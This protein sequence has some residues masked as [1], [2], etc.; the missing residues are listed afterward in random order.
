MTHHDLSLP[1]RT[2]DIAE[3]TAGLAPTTSV[4]L[5]TPSDAS[6]AA[7]RMDI[8]WSNMRREAKAAGSPQADLDAITTLIGETDIAGPT[9]VAH[10][11]GETLIAVVSGGSVRGAGFSQRPITDGVVEVSPVPALLPLL[12]GQSDV[13][14]HLVVTIDRTGADVTLITPT[15]TLETTVEGDDEHIHRGHPGGWSQRRFQQRAENTWE[16]NSK[17]VAEHV[18]DLTRR[19]GPA[20]IIVAGDERAIGFFRQHLPPVVDGIVTEIRGARVEWSERDIADRAATEVDSWAAQRKADALREFADAYATGE[21]VQGAP[22][23]LEVL[24]QGRAAR[25]LIAD[26]TSDSRR[27]TAWTAD[28]PSLCFVELTRVDTPLVEAPRADIAVRTAA[29]M[30]TDVIVVPTH[31]AASPEDG[32]GAILRG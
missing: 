5:P 32:L 23:T 16:S 21:A 17:E 13:V 15:Q 12:N 25:L 19:A 26:D 3:L 30:G 2:R 27:I 11:G 28:D 29:H 18:T 8:R 20:L 6:D 7:H 14:D 24:R 31:A 10:F 22:D 9:S 4:Y 1:L